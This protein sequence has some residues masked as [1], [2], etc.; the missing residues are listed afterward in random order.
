MPPCPYLGLPSSDAAKAL[1]I[2]PGTVCTQVHQA[3]LSLQA[4]VTEP[5]DR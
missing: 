3:R 2:S 5:Q 1:R 4:A